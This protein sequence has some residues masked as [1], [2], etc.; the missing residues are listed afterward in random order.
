MKLRRVG[1]SLGNLGDFVGGLGEFSYQLGQTLADQAPALRE[2]QGLE[3]HIHCLP[4]LH[5]CFGPGVNYLPVQRSQE[6]R[7]RAPVSL[8]LWHAT[9]QL[10]RYGPPQGHGRRLV[11]VH[12]L[13]Y[14][15]EK[16]GL[17]RWR[18]QWRMRRLLRHAD[19]L[20]AIT[21]HVAA[22]IRRELGWAGPL[23]VVHNGVRDLSREPREP[24][25]ALK[26]QPFFFHISRMT[27]NKNVEAL[28]A[29]M[30]RWPEK[31]LV[32]AGPSVARNAELQAWAERHGLAN[33]SVLTAVNDGQKAWLYAHC[34]AFFFPS[35]TEGFGLPPIEAMRFGKPTF[36]S[37]LTSLPE[38]GGDAAY[39]WPGFEPHAMRQVVEQGLA[40]HT[41][42]RAQAAAARAA[43]FNWDA[44]ARSY[45]QAY[46]A[47]LESRPA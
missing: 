26:G 22:D 9:S 41:P 20:V 13:N 11:T 35:L 15:Y 43:S 5:G 27:P 37:T 2:Q 32:L 24:L 34:E 1:I 6:W 42:A 8:D 45:V 23:Q 38:V 17:S 7:H 36:L 47:L 28:L 3:F 12:D 40:A 31:R 4:A 10:N 21:Q 16:T 33:V 25:P 39:Y 29:M 30:A 44:A 18:H 14:V 46:L 19:A